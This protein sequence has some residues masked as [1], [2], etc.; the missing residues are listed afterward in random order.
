MERADLLA[1]LKSRAQIVAVPELPAN[2][3]HLAKRIANGAFGTVYTAEAENIAEY[4]GT[5][6]SP[7]RLVAAKYLANTCDKDRCVFNHSWLFH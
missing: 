4:R 7:R 6:I 3:L 1:D 5:A 2:R